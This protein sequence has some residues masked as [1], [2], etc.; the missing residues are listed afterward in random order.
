MRFVNRETGVEPD[1][2]PDVDMDAMIDCIHKVTIEQ[3]AFS[4]HD[5]MI[6]TGGH[7]PSLFGHERKGSNGGGPVHIGEGAWLG[8][9]STIVGPVR[10]GAH[11]VI[12]AGAVVVNDV[13]EYALAVGVPARVVKR[14]KERSP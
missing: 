3:L 5:V 11:S 13:P 1:I 14:Y 7:D 2:A 10:I 8:S 6:I 12:G 4:G 9:R